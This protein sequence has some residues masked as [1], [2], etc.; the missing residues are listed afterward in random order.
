MKKDLTFNVDDYL[1][2]LETIHE[3]NFQDILWGKG[4]GA[5]LKK[6][7]QLYDKFWIQFKS[8]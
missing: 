5:R 4:L 6:R 1:K 8:I 3:I 2:R 7:N